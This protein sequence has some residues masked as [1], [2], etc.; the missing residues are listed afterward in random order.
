MRQL[1]SIAARLWTLAAVCLLVASASVLADEVVYSVSEGQHTYS[2]FCQNCHGVDGKGDGYMA[3]QLK[4]HPT[5][6][7]RLA[8]HNGGVFPAEEVRRVIDGREEIRSHGQRDMPIWGDVFLWPERESPERRAYVD[9][10]IG[11]LVEY[12]RTLQTSGESE[13]GADKDA[14]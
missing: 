9:Q 8:E 14:G 1:D 7:T 13:Q 6:L 11:E 10:K 4:T 12:L 2:T 5:D 3:D